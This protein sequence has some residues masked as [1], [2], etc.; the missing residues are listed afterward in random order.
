MKKNVIRLN[1]GQLRKVIKESV[2]KILKEEFGGGQEQPFTGKLAEIVPQ[3]E[4]ALN[5]S[6]RRLYRNMEAMNDIFDPPFDWNSP[7][8]DDYE[9]PERDTEKMSAAYDKACEYGEKICEIVNRIFG[10]D[11]YTISGDDEY[12]DP[13]RIRIEP[14]DCPYGSYSYGGSDPEEDDI[15][16]GALMYAL[17]KNVSY[18]QALR[19]KRKEADERRARETSEYE[20]KRQAELDN[21][22]KFLKGTSNMSND[23]LDRINL[24]PVGK[25]DLSKVDPK[26]MNKKRW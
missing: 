26:S 13:T 16:F 7:A 20:R 2:V 9:E 22:R 5:S 24:K 14:I 10:E 18:E 6:L 15:Y 21:K 25:I 17:R 11:R 1:E 19:A 8:I 4:Q 12:G 23:E 3:I